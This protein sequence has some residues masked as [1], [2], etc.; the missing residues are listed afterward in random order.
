[1]VRFHR[2]SAVPFD[3]DLREYQQSMALAA[4]SRR[5][6][7][8]TVSHPVRRR[9]KPQR[10]FDLD[11][12]ELPQF[13]PSE[14]DE[15]DPE[16]A[17]AVQAS[18]DSEHS[19]TQANLHS[20]KPLSSQSMSQPLQSAKEPLSP[21]PLATVPSTRLGS[22]DVDDDLYASPSRLET[23]LSIAGAG[24]PRS[25]SG[26]YA[27]QSTLFG[28]PSLLLP[29]KVPVQPSSALSTNI[30]STVDI[31][32]AGPS[33]GPSLSPLSKPQPQSPESG[34]GLEHLSNVT[35]S[36]GDDEMEEI[37]AVSSTNVTLDSTFPPVLSP[38]P[39]I[40]GDTR[41]GYLVRRSSP[42]LTV[43]SL[44]VRVPEED[45]EHSAI[46]W[47]RSPSPAG[48]LTTN[49]LSAVGHQAE[50]EEGW[51]AAQEMDPHQEAGE[52]ARFISQVK[53]KDLDTVRNEIDEEIRE[54]NRQKKAAIR[55]SEDITQHM[56]SQIM[57][58]AHS[59]ICMSL[60][61]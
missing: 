32:A 29:Q 53:G 26:H 60:E 5:S 19:L 40:N 24:P 12:D 28:T 9:I 52:F 4:V 27:Q 14:S 57:V 56:I 16:L 42:V 8:D 18:L 39:P 22:Y 23:A 1:M 13:R 2:P 45:S 50:K 34:R 54:L 37:V 48:E 15:E 58:C 36:D 46:E 59:S 6:E 43:P 25:T 17:M 49:D 35:E 51:D 31:I 7:K 30:G 47:S 3:P 38:P 55:D 41:E 33:K 21:H 10:L 20:A 61:F 44:E 11:D